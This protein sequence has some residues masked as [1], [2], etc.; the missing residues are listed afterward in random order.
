MRRAVT[1]TLTKE[2]RAMLT[3]WA[4]SRTAPMRLVSRA[5]MIL[6]AAKGFENREIAEQLGVHRV[7]AAAWRKRFAADR[8]PGIEGPGSAGDQTKALGADH[9]RGHP[10]HHAKGRHALEHAF[11]GQAFGH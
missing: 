9:R 5:K 6:L 1:I 8:I 4:G 11:A 2:E 3:K 7:T 10:A